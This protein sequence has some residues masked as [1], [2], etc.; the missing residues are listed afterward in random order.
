MI[1][2][3]E[4]NWMLE[5]KNVHP[6][7]HQVVGAD[8]YTKLG[9]IDEKRMSIELWWTGCSFDPGE[10]EFNNVTAIAF[11]FYQY[12]INAAGNQSTRRTFIVRL[13]VPGAAG[14]LP[15]WEYYNNAGGWTAIDDDARQ[16]AGLTW[17]PWNDDDRF[18]WQYSKLTINLDYE[19]DGTYQYESLTVN[20]TTWPINADCETTALGVGVFQSA[21]VPYLYSQFSASLYDVAEEEWQGFTYVDQINVWANDMQNYGAAA[22]AFGQKS[23]PGA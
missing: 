17:T 19:N 18:C 13:L 9:E 11:G 3:K 7:E 10:S 14:G 8:A 6:S 1:P 15:R 2:P 16:V 5:L 12:Y 21:L 20:D 23:G 22:T 4:G